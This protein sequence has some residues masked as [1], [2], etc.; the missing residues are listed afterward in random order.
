MEK[1]KDDLDRS[2]PTGTFHGAGEDS[3][4]KAVTS[5]MMLTDGFRGGHG[6]EQWH[7]QQL[8]RPGRPVLKWEENSVVEFW[9]SQG[10]PKHL[11]TV[12]YTGSV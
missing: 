9:D 2:N 11:C 3:T 1:F 6:M 5:R 8:Q 7:V 4:G 10:S 12:L